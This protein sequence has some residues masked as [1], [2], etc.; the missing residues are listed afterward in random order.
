MV[1][2]RDVQSFQQDVALNRWL[3]E[4]RR[5][6]DASSLDKFSLLNTRTAR[7]NATQF[8]DQGM[9]QAAQQL[10]VAADGRKRSIAKYYREQLLKN[11]ALGPNIDRLQPGWR[12]W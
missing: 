9:A 4:T 6:L 12:N 7:L 1:P 3:T 2:R 10:V 11:P 8:K 5:Q